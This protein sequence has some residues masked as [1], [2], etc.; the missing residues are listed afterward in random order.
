M[1]LVNINMECNECD[2][3]W[4]SNF[5]YMLISIPFQSEGFNKTGGEMN[6][7]Y[8]TSRIILQVCIHRIIRMAISYLR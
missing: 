5:S 4:K 3:H 6:T 2:Y 8:Y 1:I 7:N